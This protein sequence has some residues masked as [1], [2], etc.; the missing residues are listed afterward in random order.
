MEWTET[1]AAGMRLLSGEWRRWQVL[2]SFGLPHQAVNGLTIFQNG[3][4]IVARSMP[5]TVAVGDLQRMAVQV[6]FAHNVI[7]EMAK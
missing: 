5:A 2:I 1:N 3:R 4:V 6:I 7:E